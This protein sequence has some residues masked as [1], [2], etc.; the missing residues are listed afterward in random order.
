M[1]EHMTVNPVAPLSKMVER[2]R[3][4]ANRTQFTVEASRLLGDG[5]A[6]L[7]LL[8]ANIDAVENARREPRSIVKRGIPADAHASDAIVEPSHA[9]SSASGLSETLHALREKNFLLTRSNEQLTAL[10]HSLSHDL[11]EPLHTVA[12]Y[13][14]LLAGSQ[15]S[16]LSAQDRQHLRCV[17]Q[18]CARLQSMLSSLLEYYRAD[19]LDN[20]SLAYVDASEPLKDALLNLLGVIESSGAEVEIGPM[21]VVLAH[22]TALL[23]VFQNLVGNAIRYRAQRVPRIVISAARD[24]A[25]WRLCVAD[26]GRGFNPKQAERIFELFARGQGTGEDPGSGVGLATCKRLVERHGGRIWAE[27]TPGEGSRF[28]FTLPAAR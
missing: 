8:G 20:S 24:A 18:G 13:S 12:M 3:D 2:P 23:Q 7:I 19:Q 28:Y 22:P 1:E 21:P 10:C 9:L 25:F 27:S 17:R 15:D 16:L 26:N 14:D 11:R 4:A 5:P 6:D